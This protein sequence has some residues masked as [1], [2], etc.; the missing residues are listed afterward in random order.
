MLLI[1]LSGLNTED[2]LSK[3]KEVL[4]SIVNHEAV[5][6]LLNEVPKRRYYDIFI[7]GQRLHIGKHAETYGNATAVRKPSSAHMIRESTIRLF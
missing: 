2:H 3:F 6:I 7:D 5:P 1:L 4:R